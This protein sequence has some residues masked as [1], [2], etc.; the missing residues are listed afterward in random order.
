MKEIVVGFCP[1]ICYCFSSCQRYIYM[2]FRP[3]MCLN[4]AAAPQPTSFWRY[5]V[6]AVDNSKMGNRTCG[7]YWG[8]RGG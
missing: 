6:F 1:S 4:S 3:K 8:I 2:R 7:Q 5:H